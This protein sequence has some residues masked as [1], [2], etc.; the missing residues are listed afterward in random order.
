MQ[1]FVDQV[2]SPAIKKIPILLRV[3]YLICNSCTWH[4]CEG[5]AYLEK[6]LP[7]SSMQAPCRLKVRGPASVPR[8]GG[9]YLPAV[10]QR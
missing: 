8:Q 7:C 10:A 9:Q 6:P 5:K 2:G 3:P 4:F 1:F